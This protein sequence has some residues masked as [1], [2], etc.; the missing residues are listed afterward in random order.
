[1]FNQPEVIKQKVIPH[2]SFP[3]SYDADIIHTGESLK[4]AEKST[5]GTL[6]HDSVS[7]H[8]GLNWV[9]GAWNTNEVYHRNLNA[10]PPH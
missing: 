7:M 10:G 1:M 8:K 2:E 3:W 5:G 4:N 6:T 9:E